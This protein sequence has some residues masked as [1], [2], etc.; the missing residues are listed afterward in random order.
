MDPFKTEENILF[1]ELKLKRPRLSQKTK[2]KIKGH[3]GRVG[4]DMK[5]RLYDLI[6]WSLI[7]V[8][9]GTIFYLVYP[10]YYFME[11]GFLRGNTITGEV[12][13]FDIYSKKWVS[14]DEYRFK[15]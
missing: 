4:D 3:P 15:K 10:R 7:I 9:V 8:I 6:K 5:E 12:H 11:R 1:A 2:L 14:L 13:R